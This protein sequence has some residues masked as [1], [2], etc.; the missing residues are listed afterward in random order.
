[1]NQ[2]IRFC[3]GPDDVCLAYATSGSGPP[4]VRV[5]N[6]LTHVDLDWKGPLWGHWFDALSRGHTLVRYDARGTGLSDRNVPELS[7]NA[8][9]EDLKTVVDDLG[10]DRFPIFGFCQGGA[11]AVAFAI[12]YPERVSKLILY[13]C[14]DRGAF[15]EG[16]ATGVRRQARVLA[17]MI[18]I[19]W[20]QNASA[21]R[22]VF[23]NLLLPTAPKSL[24]RWLAELQRRTVDPD[25]A[26]RLWRVFNELD[27]RDR[28][29]QVSVPA[30]QFHVRNDAMV[31]F[32]TGR[33]LSSL[34]P[35]T[36]FVP[37]DGQN[38]ILLE[39]DPAW[40]RFVNEVRKFLGTTLP[41]TDEMD[42]SGP[43]SE[44]TPRER[45][46]LTLVSD[47]LGNGEIADRLYI[48]PKTVRNHVTRIYSKI[49]VNSRAEAVVWARD[50]GL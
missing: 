36:R 45:E 17:E 31:P 50:V 23:S 43:L 34:I 24:Q 10:L 27:I 4:L 29:T 8:W 16:T 18:E 39:D 9:V 25:T 14:Y 20:G 12:R 19:G 42:D 49:D 38:H 35:N 47:G 5:A 46:V 32:E 40:P 11:V 3:T 48:A 22:E 44:L 41:D 28:A 2:N 26:A 30:L 15:V 1:M 37:L 6:W 21:F 7:L 33:R 13:D